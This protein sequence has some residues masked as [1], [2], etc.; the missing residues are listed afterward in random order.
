[1]NISSSC[2]APTLSYTLVNADGTSY[3]GG[4]ITID[5]VGN[6]LI[7][8]ATMR[9]ET[10]YIQAMSSYGIVGNLL[11]INHA[12]CGSEVIALSKPGPLNFVFEPMNSL[13][14]T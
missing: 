11:A 1:M 3:T 5:G 2:A 7:Y 8:T 9:S 13:H 12:V 6:L 4:T 10:T 14:F